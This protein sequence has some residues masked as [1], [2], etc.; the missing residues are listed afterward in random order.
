MVM[1]DTYGLDYDLEITKNIPEG[2]DWSLGLKQ[3]DVIK[4]SELLKAMVIS[5]YN[6]AAYALANE[7]GYDGYLGLMN[8]K[9]T[10]LGCKD[11]HFVNPTGLHDDNHYSTVED[12]TRIMSA[13]LKYPSILEVGESLGS[14][15]VWISEEN[16][17]S[18]YIYT[19]NQLLGSNPYVKGLKTGYTDEAG[20]CLITRYVKGSDEYYI[21]IVGSQDRFG[22]TSKIINNL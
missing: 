3:G 19:T 12:L 18:E 5:S 11:S 13:V 1:I 15:V 9:L 10:E 17:K 7:F 2:Y 4:T 6:D 14:E 21:I 8:K 22:D 16:I 20:Q